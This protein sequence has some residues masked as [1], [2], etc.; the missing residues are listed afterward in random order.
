MNQFQSLL[1]S[2]KAKDAEA[3][4]LIPELQKMELAEAALLHYRQ[5][6]LGNRF[7]AV[8][9]ALETAAA[10]ARTKRA[11]LWH[12]DGDRIHLRIRYARLRPLQD[13]NPSE[14]LALLGR[15]LDQAGFTLSLG[16]GKNPRPM[17]TLGHPLPIGTEG[18]EEWADAVLQQ[19]PDGDPGSWRE[20]LNTAAP[21]GLSF[22]A[23]EVVPSY[24]SPVLDLS[25]EAHWAWPCPAEHFAGAQTRIAAF[26]ASTSFELEKPGKAEGA[27]TL[28]KVD[29]RPL[30]TTALWEG[31]TLQLVLRIRT[32]EAMNPR[33]LMGGILGLDPSHIEGLVRRR[34]VLSEDA[35]IKH[36]EK[37]EPKLKN[38]FEDAVLLGEGGNLT[39]VDEDEDEPLVLG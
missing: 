14:T 12:L 29:V 10:S 4:L 15:T 23:L 9:K 38:I 36:A 25:R 17:V 11:S 27:K 1:A 32:G 33:K 20:R 35:R 7:P 37:F 34:V 3:L 5:A 24:A 13:L 39:L 28:K 31:T 16:L 8:R 18:L 21:R 2:P 22:G 19:R 26:L 6:R 30:V